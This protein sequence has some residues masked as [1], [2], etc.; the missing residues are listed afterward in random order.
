MNKM[1]VA[2]YSVPQNYHHMNHMWTSS[3]I[4]YNGSK[5]MFCLHEEKAEERKARKWEIAANNL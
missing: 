5:S 2:S 3:K 4:W 1:I